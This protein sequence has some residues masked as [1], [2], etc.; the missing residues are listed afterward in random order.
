MYTDMT[1]DDNKE[2]EQILKWLLNNGYYI[3]Q[4]PNVI[5]KQMSLKRFAYDEIK[6]KYEKM[7]DIVLKIVY[8]GLNVGN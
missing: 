4:F 6:E 1:I 5:Q 3:K 2:Y 8:L 7:K